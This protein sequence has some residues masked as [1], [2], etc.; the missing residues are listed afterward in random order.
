MWTILP[1]PS[2]PKYSCTSLVK[3]RCK[4]G[5][6]AAFLR[7]IKNTTRDQLL[8]VQLEASHHCRTP[9]TYW[10]QYCSAFLLTTWMMGKAHSH[11]V[12][13]WQKTGRSDWQAK[14]L[15]HSSDEPQQLGEMGHNVNSGKCKDLYLGRNYNRQ[16]MMGSYLETKSEEKDLGS[17]WTAS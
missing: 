7:M 8:V 14:W 17:W 10:S 9:G 2:N 6:S 13:W 12:C 11:N 16:Q 5:N 4:W 3:P 1:T 15:C